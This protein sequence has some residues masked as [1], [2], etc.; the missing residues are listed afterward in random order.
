MLST[1]HINV[2]TAH[3]NVTTEHKNVTT[4]HNNVTTAHNNFQHHVTV[5]A[6]HNE[7]VSRLISDVFATAM[8]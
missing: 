2:T 5:V 7:A 4:S 8:L 1:E 3:N 6:F